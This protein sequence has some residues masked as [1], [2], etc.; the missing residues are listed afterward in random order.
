MMQKNPLLVLLRES[1]IIDSELCAPC[2]AFCVHEGMSVLITLKRVIF[3]LIVVEAR[4]WNM[5]GY[6]NLHIW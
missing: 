1:S 3:F 5:Q 4:P 6:S 2:K